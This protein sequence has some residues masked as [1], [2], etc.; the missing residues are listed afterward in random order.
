MTGVRQI[1]VF[2]SNRPG[3][4]AAIT[5]ALAEAAINIMG[6]NIASSGDFGVIKFLV[7]DLEKADQVLR[8][9]GF[10]VSLNEVLA[11]EMDDAPGGLHRIADLLYRKNINVEYS[12]GLP[13]KPHRSAILIIEVEDIEEAKRLLKDEPLRFLSETEIQK[14]RTP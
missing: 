9:K 12:Y 7:N 13:M 2:A 5:G 11:I 4:I 10:T 1:S 8:E 14:E 6:M 3:K